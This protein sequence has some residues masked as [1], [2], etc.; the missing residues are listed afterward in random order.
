MLQLMRV[1]L[2]AGSSTKDISISCAILRSLISSNSLFSSWSLAVRSP[3]EQNNKRWLR[4]TVI[5]IINHYFASRQ[6]TAWVWNGSS[7]KVCENFFRWSKDTHVWNA[8]YLWRRRHL[9]S[10]RCC[11]RPLAWHSHLPSDWPLFPHLSYSFLRTDLVPLPK[12]TP[13]K[14]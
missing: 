1:T 2:T 14:M 4:I 7:R 11:T 3:W 12:Q 9:S 6:D 10:S 8:D 13:F 5:L